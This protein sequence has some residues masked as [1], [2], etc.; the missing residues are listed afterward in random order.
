MTLKQLEN[1]H[2]IHFLK[3]FTK[4]LIINLTKGNEIEVEKIKQKFIEPTLI[5]EQ[6]FKKIIQ[7]PIFESTR[8][9][10]DFEPT[11]A[12]KQIEREEIQSRKPTHHRIKLPRRMPT[13]KANNYINPTGLKPIYPKETH[14]EETS[15]EKA[16]REIQPEY[17]PKPTGFQLGKIEI[18][19]K[20][21]L[22]QSIEC[23]GPG[24]NLLIKKYGK[25]NITKITLTKE[26]INE[27]VDVFSKEAKIPVVGGI[28]KAAVGDLIISAVTSEFVGSR[29]IISRMTPR[30]EKKS[31]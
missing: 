19:F 30:L 18:L 14:P 22:I 27:I 31:P 29:F 13:Q 1:T 8:F 28:L 5:P 2:R 7:S 11:R 15:Q 4:E 25:S 10:K 12:P 9:T 20:D 16:L 21:S 17:S 24:K 23:L 26:E 3:K 6:A